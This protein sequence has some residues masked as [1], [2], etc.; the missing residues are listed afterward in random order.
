METVTFS[1]GLSQRLG[2][3][4]SPT[5]NGVP[6]ETISPGSSG[7]IDEMY[8][9]SAGILKINSLVFECCS[10]SPSMVSCTSRLCGSAIWSEVTIAGPIGQKVGRLFDSDHCEV[11]N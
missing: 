6:V 2:L 5:P 8:S 10:T 7:V 1:P 3:R 9:I 11:E 4:P